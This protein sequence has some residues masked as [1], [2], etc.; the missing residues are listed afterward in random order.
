VY[1]KLKLEERY[2]ICPRI[3][4]PKERR[5]GIWVRFKVHKQRKVRINRR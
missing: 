5:R 3:R 4:K 2:M 1:A